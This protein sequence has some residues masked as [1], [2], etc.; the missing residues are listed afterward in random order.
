MKKLVYFLIVGLAF[1]AHQVAHSDPMKELPPGLQERDGSTHQILNN[2][3]SG[4]FIE[5]SQKLDDEVCTEWVMEKGERESVNPQG[6]GSPAPATIGG[7][8]SVIGS[9]IISSSDGQ[10]IIGAPRATPPRRGMR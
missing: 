9:S 7:A 3:I 8:S 6:P 5:K 4:D 2:L 10:G 1:T